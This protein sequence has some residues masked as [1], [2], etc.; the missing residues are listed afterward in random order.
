MNINKSKVLYTFPSCKSCKH[1]G[2]LLNVLPNNLVFFKS[3]NTEID[4]I[5]RTLTDK[6][7]TLLQIK[8]KVSL[9]L[10]INK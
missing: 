2:H 1:Y 4:E 10:R 8:D 7:G 5:F 6:N 9:T 3:F